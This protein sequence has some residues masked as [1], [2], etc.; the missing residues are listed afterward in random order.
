M[1]GSICSGF[2]SLQDSSGTFLPEK[3]GNDTM[4][5]SCLKK[6]LQEKTKD[7]LVI[8]CSKCQFMSIPKKNEN[9]RFAV[10]FYP[11]KLQLFDRLNDS[12]EA[13]CLFD[14]HKVVFSADVREER[15]STIILKEHGI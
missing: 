9:I 15:I 13:S 11:W 2:F 12:E 1:V 3:L 5:A 4:K 7:K 6:T 8:F 14:D 10:Q